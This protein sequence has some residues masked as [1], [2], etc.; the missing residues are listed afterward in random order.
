[1]SLQNF[2]CH[3]N[4]L[5]RQLHIRDPILY[6]E[7][8]Q[9]L[10]TISRNFQYIN[11]IFNKLHIQM[12]KRTWKVGYERSIGKLSTKIFRKYAHFFKLL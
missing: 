1:M 5:T 8:K 9:L 3:D 6:K 11:T 7:K 2:E 12:F 10:C 4:R